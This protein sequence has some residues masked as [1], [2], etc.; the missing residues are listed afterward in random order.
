[1]KISRI[2]FVHLSRRRFCYKLL[3]TAS[4]VL[5]GR[6]TITTKASESIASGLAEYTIVN[7]WILTK[8]DVEL[9][10]ALRP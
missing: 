8:T 2:D 7:G 6:A 1:M 3:G 9:L 10:H 4:V 5:L